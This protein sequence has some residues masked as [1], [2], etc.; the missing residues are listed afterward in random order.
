MN[1][2]VRV[3]VG[4]GKQNQNHD[5]DQDDILF[6][7]SG[8]QHCISEGE[9]EAICFKFEK[10]FAFG[11]QVLFLWFQICYGDFAGVELWVPFNLWKKSNKIPSGSKYWRAWSIANGG[12]PKRGDRMSPRIFLQRRFLISVVTVRRD[13]KQRDLPDFLQYSRGDDVLQKLT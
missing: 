2:T 7:S 6:V 13:S 8:N 4:S 3:S 5:Q 11:R 10:A 1:V 9:Y 12:R